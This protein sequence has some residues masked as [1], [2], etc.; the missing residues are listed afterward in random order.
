[1]T[2]KEVDKS[3]FFTMSA[4]GVL[5]HIGSEIVFTNLD[6]W[7]EEYDMYCRLMDIKTFHNFRTWKGF[8]VWRKNI[9]FDKFSSAQSRLTSNMLMLN[10][11]LREALI[12][13]QDMCCS[14][15]NESFVDLACVENLWLFYFI[16]TQVMMAQQN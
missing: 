15:V 7:E 12:S 6:K 16:E 8:Y 13:I 11:I 2:Y 1:M 14:M 4:K 10:D 3:N 5:Q 9:L